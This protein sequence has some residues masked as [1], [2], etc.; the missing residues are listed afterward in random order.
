M[1]RRGKRTVVRA[2]MG[3]FSMLAGTLLSLRPFAAVGVTVAAVAVGLVVWAAAEGVQSSREAPARGV[4]AAL[5]LSGAVLIAAWPGV[6]LPVVSAAVGML[7]FAAGVLEI[8]SGLLARA[9]LP[10]ML[11]GAAI[12]GISVTVVTGSITVVLGVVTALWS[13]PVVL[14]VAMTLGA[15][16]LVVGAGLLVDLWYPPTAFGASTESRRL[17]WR[18]VALGL[19]VALTAVG[20]LQDG[21]RAW[22]SSFYYRD[23]AQDA[24]PGTL[25]RAE[26][27]GGVSAPGATS[28]R[29]LYVTTDGAGT[30]TTASAVLVVPG[31]TQ[32]SALPLVVWAHGETGTG[33]GCAP[34]VIGEARGGLL[35]VDRLVAAG[36]A[37]L[38]PDYPG[39]GAPGRPSF[40]VGSAEGHA[41]LDAVRAAG[42]VPGLKLGKAV[43]WGYSQ[44]GHAALWA[45]QLAPTYAPDVELSGVVVDAPLT[46][47]GAVLAAA[48]ASDTGGSLPASLLSSYAAT[49][50]EVTVT[51]Y[52]APA[53][54]LRADEAAARCGDLGWAVANWVAVAGAN[55]SWRAEPSSGALG[56]RLIQNVPERLA[57]PLM[58]TQGTDD[59]VV[60]VALIDR[61]VALRCQS[62]QV[63]DYRVYPGLGRR[64]P[65][66]ADAPQFADTM[67][68]IA[69]RFGSQP[70]TNTCK[71]VRQP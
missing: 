17:G 24:R 21:G 10:R 15:R 9:T 50:P 23:V 60:P 13:D 54:A 69:A 30:A 47:P 37:V 46:D 45:G 22:P 36:Y 55:G 8:W 63:V 25:L 34:S 27:Y 56:P 26:S 49:Y 70:A 53:E 39:L 19:A 6:P 16:L 20:I 32:A 66:E 14:P 59:P 68:W 2:A 42:G 38:A 52:L 48:L 62:A 28:V 7:M 67:A 29:L 51:D 58:V 41:L 65:A 43:L 61:F 71:A 5:C 11:V 12:G 40:L 44:G 4:L 3:L 1:A 18:L 33:Q 57:V 31:S 64:S 35:A